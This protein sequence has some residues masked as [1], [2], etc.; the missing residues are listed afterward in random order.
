M[1]LLKGVLTSAA[2][3]TISSILEKSVH[4][5]YILFTKPHLLDHVKLVLALH[6]VRAR[7]H[8][9][10]Q[11]A[12]KRSN[13]VTFSNYRVSAVSI[14][15][16]R[17]LGVKLELEAESIWSRQVEISLVNNSIWTG[18]IIHVNSPSITSI[19]SNQAGGSI[20]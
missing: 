7:D 17:N 19:P 12:T 4:G 13:T 14:C 15:L 8:H 6:V 2:S 18:S 10:S 1:G 3:A 20:G 9:P 16:K 11:E 5:Q